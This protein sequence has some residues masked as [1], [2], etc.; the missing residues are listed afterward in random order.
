MKIFDLDD[1]APDQVLNK[2]LG[3]LETLKN[4]D[5][6]VEFEDYIGCSNTVMSHFSGKASTMFEVRNF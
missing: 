6:N 3:H 5:D 4:D 2:F 1:K